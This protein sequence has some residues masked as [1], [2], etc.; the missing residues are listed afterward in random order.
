[1]SAGTLGGS[2]NWLPNENGNVE[3]M[4][5]VERT[6]SNVVEWFWKD[7]EKGKMKIKKVNL[8]VYESTNEALGQLVW[9]GRI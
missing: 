1:M 4:R 2:D 8:V 5:V 6:Y 9:R 7:G 3:T